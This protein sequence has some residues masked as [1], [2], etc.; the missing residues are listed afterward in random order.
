MPTPRGKSV[1]TTSFTDS[2]FG[3]CKITGR[4]TTSIIHLVN[5]TP[6]E[7]Y[8]KRQSTMETSTYGAEFVA[9]KICIEQV[10]ALRYQLQMMGIPIDRPSYMFR[11]NKSVVKSATIP[12][13]NIKKKHTAN[14]YHCVREA[15]AMKLIKF[16]HIEG[17]N[18][19]ADV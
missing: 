2:N 12:E 1:I 14:A 8:T 16:I 10:I 18:N 6:I 9:P 7:W 4:Y 11:D 15:I 13:N 19:P 5:K 3:N 17:K